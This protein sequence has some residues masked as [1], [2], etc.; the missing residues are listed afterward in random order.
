MITSAGYQA[1]FIRWG[2]VQGAVVIIAALFLKS[3]PGRLV[4]EDLEVQGQ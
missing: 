1:T 2:I 3:P 4:A